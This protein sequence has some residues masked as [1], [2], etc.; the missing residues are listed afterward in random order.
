MGV[1]ESLYQSLIGYIVAFDAKQSAVINILSMAKDL[2]T[3]GLTI[4]IL[5]TAFQVMLNRNT[6]PFNEVLWS[7]FK[8]A[9]ILSVVF[10]SV[11]WIN[12]ASP[13]AQEAYNLFSQGG[14]QRFPAMLDK[15]LKFLANEFTDSMTEKLTFGAELIIIPF[16][17]VATFIVFAIVSLI[18][19]SF[20]ILTTITSHLLVVVLPFAIISLL[21][22]QTKEIFAQWL[23]LFISN[24]LTV[25]LGFLVIEVFLINIF[26]AEFQ[27]I[28]TSKSM[29]YTSVLVLFVVTLIGVKV[30]LM[31]ISLAQNLVGVS[32]DM[33][34]GAGGGATAALG[35]GGTAMGMASR[36][37]TSGAKIGS[38]KALSGAKIGGQMVGNFAKKLDAKTGEHIA[39]MFRNKK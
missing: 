18:T 32:L 25:L 30:F 16:Y 13:V 20:L 21:Y 6:S 36:L 11:N 27:K 5:W 3:I 7:M 4:S 33:A 26:N 24:L 9:I 1:F 8:R 12:Y 14:G 10:G 2:I 22:N 39:N 37:G 19:M 38:A 23:K 29:E 17:I 31:A 35:A 34:S 28:A 15:N